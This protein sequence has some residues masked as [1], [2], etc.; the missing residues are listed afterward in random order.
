M[1]VVTTSG[2]YGYDR[3]EP[4]VPQPGELDVYAGRYTSPELDVTWTLTVEGDYLVAHRR[5][6]VDSVLTP[7]FRDTFSDDWTPLM[8]FP[9]GYG[10]AFERDAA[11]AVTGLRV[12]GTGVR[13]LH[14]VRL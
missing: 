13:H 6:Y 2:V 14:F 9:F 3:V 4:F 8:G 5:K 11:G 12:S 10:I 7:L 1:Q